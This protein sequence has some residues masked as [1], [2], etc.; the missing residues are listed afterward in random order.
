MHFAN[1]MAEPADD[2][3]H[4][5]ITAV[6]DWEFAGVVSSARWNPRKAFLWIGQQS[7]QA[8]EE[9]GRLWQVFE[10]KCR[11]KNAG[12]L[13]QEFELNKLQETTHT[14][15]SYIRAIVEVCPKGVWEDLQR[16]EAWR[17]VAEAA[18]TAEIDEK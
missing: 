2:G 10:R 11:E 15:V 5:K 12:R 9:Q 18:M 4:Y 8:K 1:I 16:A 6:L 17:K 14:V 13:L 3:I 7:T